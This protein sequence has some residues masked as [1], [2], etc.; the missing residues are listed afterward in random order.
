MHLI[1]K[2]KEITEN[3]PTLFTT[4]GHSQGKI[5]FPPLKKVIGKKV[6]KYDYSEVLGLDNL[7][8]PS[9]TLLKS[10]LR[11]G[12]IYDSKASFYL[13]NGS[14]SGITA[15]MLATAKKG[16]KILI[17]RN[18]HKSVIN[19]L[20]LTGAVPVWLDVD[21]I[22][23]WNIS[24][25]VCTAK[26]KDHLDNNPDITSVWI[27]NPTYEGI[28]ADVAEISRVCK[29][30]NVKLIVD[31]A[32]GALWNF[33][34]DL[35]EPAIKL[36]ADASVQSLHKSASCLTQ[37]AILHISKN[38]SITP[39]K[40]QECLNI[41]NT[42]SPS[43]ILLASI[44]GAIEHINS[45]QGEKN[46]NKLL[47]N[48]EKFKQKLQKY[49]EITFYDVNHD[50][51]KLLFKLKDIS[52]NLVAE[53]L[54]NKRNIEVELNSDISLMAHT[55]IG[56]TKKQ[57]DKLMSSLILAINTL[58]KR[59]SA[60]ESGN[61]FT[62]AYVIFSPA[63]AFY[64]KSKILPIQECQGLVSKETIVPYPPGIPILICGEL[65]K[66][67]HIEYLIKTGKKSLEIITD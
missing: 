48:I 62:S 56:T 6:F 45:L 37:G 11:S 41:T 66:Q 17:A 10:Q 50:P 38:T 8:D 27:T 7:Q 49:P 65:I 63:E 13:T 64:K 36:G 5:I 18:A 57:L 21:W 40:M 31:E 28:I 15:L 58:P 54:E 1:N 51:T 33:H 53:H 2:L 22:S 60:P 52:G 47:E 23:D 43:Y 20:I 67:N 55:G 35:P 14:S 32:H 4:P 9:D 16:E 59:S 46:L 25:N 39:A 42:T 34:N 19:A 3:N 24:N 44:E 26:I 61:Y 30:K 29:E 12:V